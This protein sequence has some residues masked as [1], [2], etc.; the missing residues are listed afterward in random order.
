MKTSMKRW[1]IQGFT[2]LE[3][4][5]VMTIVSAFIYAGVGYIQQRTQA[6]SIDRAAGQ[7]QQILNGA[8]AYYVGNGKWPVLLTDLQTGG[9]LPN[10]TLVSPWATTYKISNNGALFTVSTELPTTL[11]NQRAIGTILAGKLP[12][13]STNTVTSIP[14][15]TPPA[16]CIPPFNT[17]TVTASVNIPGQNLNNATAVNF[18]G[19]YHNGACVPVPQ[20]PTMPNGTAMTPSIIVSPGSVSGMNDASSTDV[21]PISSFTAY[22]TGPGYW[23]VPASGTPPASC[24][25]S[26]STSNTCDLN[27]S[28]DSAAPAGQY[29]RVCLKVQ[30]A[31][32]DVSWSATTGQYATVVVSTRCVIP[33]ERSGSSLNVW[34]Q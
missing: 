14:P 15:C 27:A 34:S 19:I 33:N 10:T 24:N 11:A 4:L 22:A 3:M 5:L 12:L 2:L 25:N 29:W 18:T 16:P 20:C 6:L 17:T 13:A 26:T 1:A 28:G 31:K 30:T 23:N 21:Y 7:I 9:Y 32:G 8:L